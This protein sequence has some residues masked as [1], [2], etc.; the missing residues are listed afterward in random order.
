MKWYNI[1]DQ[2]PKPGQRVLVHIPFNPILKQDS[3]GDTR[4][5]EFYYG[6]Y[7]VEP[8]FRQAGG[9]QELAVKHWMEIP[10]PPKD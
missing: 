8:M 1:E 9:P 2:L 5:A 6:N 4:I 3:Y 7:G 10:E